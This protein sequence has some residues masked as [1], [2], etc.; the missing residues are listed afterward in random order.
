V[1]GA[2]VVV[3]GGGGGVVTTGALVEVELV[4]MLEEEDEDDDDDEV[5]VEEL[6]ELLLEVLVV[7]FVVLG[8]LADFVT[9]VPFPGAPRTNWCG[10]YGTHVVITVW[11]HEQACV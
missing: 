9:V 2:D 8:V 3:V 5:E 4:V 7:D 6:L 11:K 10:L 1:A